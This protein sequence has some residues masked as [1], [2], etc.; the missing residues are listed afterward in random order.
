MTEYVA[1]YAI[2]GKE[3][4]LVKARFAEAQRASQLAQDLVR[5]IA[6]R[7]E[8]ENVEFNLETG[9]FTRPV[10]KEEKEEK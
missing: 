8:L 6:E 5:F 3:L 1:A 9:E 2:S 7:E 10:E 4:E